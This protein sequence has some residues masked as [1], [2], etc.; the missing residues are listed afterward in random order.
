MANKN[1]NQF[2][3]F[4]TLKAQ[5]GEG[6]ELLGLLADDANYMKTYLGCEE[7]RVF[8]DAKDS[9]TICV[10]ESWTDENLHKHAL[11]DPKIKDS[12]TRGM[13]LIVKIVSQMK[14]LETF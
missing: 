12:I 3:L 14:L 7:Y 1:M 6:K 5:P 9:D 2:I 10:L 4:T 13:P 8:K 11:N